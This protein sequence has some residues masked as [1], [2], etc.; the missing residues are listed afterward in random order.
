MLEQIEAGEDIRDLKMNVLQAI[1]YIVQ[2]WDEITVKTI[3]NC[4][5]HTEILSPDTD[6]IGLHDEVGETD[7]LILDELRNGLKALRLPNA[8]Q[9][10]EFLTIPEEDITYE[11]LEDDQIIAELVNI[12]KSG[13]NNINDLDEMDD[14]TEIPIINTNVAFKSLENIRTFLLQ[15][16]DTNEHIKL[17]SIIEKFIRK[18]KINLMQQ[19]TI[20]QYFN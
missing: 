9:M 5:Y 10:K 7:N 2:S 15:Q 11:V 8:M 4:W 19:T 17:M 6:D 14:S 12:F 18:Q 16:E 20:D 1:R 3:Q 13:E